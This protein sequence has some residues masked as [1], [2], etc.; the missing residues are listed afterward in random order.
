[1][2]KYKRIACLSPKPSDNDNR[3]IC[4]WVGPDD[5]ER[6]YT[7]NQRNLNKFADEAAA[8]ATLDTWTNN[9]FGYV[10]SDIW[11]HKNDDGTW[12]MATGASPPE[13]W[14]ED[15]PETP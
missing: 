4:T 12:A 1:M 2:A 11:F 10:L 3:V 15:I 5:I 9:N 8:K 7:V 6:T 14:P 13:V